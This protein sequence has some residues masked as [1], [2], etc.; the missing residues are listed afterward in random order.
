MKKI[1]WEKYNQIKQNNNKM[2]ANKFSNSL[3]NYH[4]LKYVTLIYITIKF[5]YSL[6][7]KANKLQHHFRKQNP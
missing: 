3:N 5:Y 7:L 6:S 2:K 4:L 1:L